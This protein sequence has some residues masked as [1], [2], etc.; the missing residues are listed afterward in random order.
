VMLAVSEFD[1]N[2]HSWSSK[3]SHVRFSWLTGSPSGGVLD[4]TSESRLQKFAVG[5]WW[6]SVQ[7]VEG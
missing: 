7:M 3:F 5:R 1:S 6:E 4:I 2:A